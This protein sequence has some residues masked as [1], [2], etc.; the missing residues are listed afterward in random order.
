MNEKKNAVQ[1]PAEKKDNK[2]A[3]KATTPAT[4]KAA[5]PKADTGLKLSDLATVY[6][7]RKSLF[8]RQHDGMQKRL[9][10]VRKNIDRLT[11][12]ASQLEQK[13]AGLVAPSAKDF[14]SP[15][16][17]A[18]VSQ[19]P[20]FSYEVAGPTGIANAVT[21]VFAPKDTTEE[22]RMR[23]EKC[24][25]ITI[26]TKTKDGTLGIR[27]YSKDLKTYAPGSVGYASGLNFATIPVPENATVQ[28]FAGHVK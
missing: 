10:A 12:V 17:K 16:A 23:G 25:T 27:D 5:T 14:I 1:K 18:L 26:I 20:G 9:D 2:V 22:E 21:I 7:R 28:F 15:L 19:F 6:I 3:A 8:D 11:E 24:K 4:V 13:L